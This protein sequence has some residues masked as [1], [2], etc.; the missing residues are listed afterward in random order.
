MIGINAAMDDGMLD[1]E[2]YYITHDIPPGVEL[3][4][5]S[6][7]TLI[8]QYLA[9]IHQHDK[10]PPCARIIIIALLAQDSVPVTSIIVITPESNPVATESGM[11][12]LFPQLC[13]RITSLP[14][15][16]ETFC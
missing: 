14:R 15:L 8:P 6:G 11:I 9:I 3:L 4:P 10:L 13:P 5:D 12:P 2:L 1:I 7:T 16:P